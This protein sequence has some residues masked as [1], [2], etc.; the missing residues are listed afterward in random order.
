[1]R[2]VIEKFF[3]ALVKKED[4]EKVE[5]L[6]ESKE[7]GKQSKLDAI[8]AEYVP[9]TADYKANYRPEAIEAKKT[10]SRTNLM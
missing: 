3:D 5:D 2:Y 4:K 10:Q 9:Y 1:M 7:K 8:V 6:R